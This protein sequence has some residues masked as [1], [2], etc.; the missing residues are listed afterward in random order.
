MR[1]L[2]ASQK[3]K[4]RANPVAVLRAGVL[5]CV[6]SFETKLEMAERYVREGEYHVARQREIIAHLTEHGRSTELAERLLL[7]LEDLLTLHRGHLAR[8]KIEHR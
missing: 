8:I 2:G 3:G 4:R 7:N 5:E 6:S 1:R